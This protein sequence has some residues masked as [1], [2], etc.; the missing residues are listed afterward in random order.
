MYMSNQEV[1]YKNKAK[2]RKKNG[3]RKK[4][5]MKEKLIF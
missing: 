2:S 5:L 4:I 1:I 3:K